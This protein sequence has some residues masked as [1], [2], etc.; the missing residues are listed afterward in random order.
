VEDYD[1]SI[2]ADFIRE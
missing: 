1:A 2:D